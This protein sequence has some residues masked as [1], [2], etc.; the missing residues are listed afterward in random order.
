MY[1]TLIDQLDALRGRTARF[2]R[3]AVHVHSPDSRDWG[4]GAADQARNDRSRFDGDS[5]LDEFAG[6]LREH[7]DCVAVTDHMRSDF[8]TRLSSRV[9]SNDE[10]MVLPGME[11]NLR[12]EP[13][14]G[15]D[16]I[17]VLTILPEG[18]TNE[19]FSRL[20][21][22]QT[23]I[24]DDAQRTGQEDV[25]GLTLGEW[26][27]RVHKEQGIC[28]AA[29]LE[30]DQGIRCRFRQVARENLLLVCGDD[31]VEAE[32]ANSVPENL[33]H[34]LY[35]SGVDAIEIHAS[36]DVTHY[37]WVSEVDGRTR[38]I[39]TMLTFDAHNVEG[40]A[41]ADRVTHIKMT[42]LGLSGLKQALM[43]PDTRIRYP[44]NLPTPPSPRIL[45]VQIRGNED[46]F[47]ED[48][49]IAF[50]ENLNC[51]IGVRGSGKSTVVEALRYVFGYNE[52]LDELDASLTENVR[53][54]QRATLP[55]SVIRVPYRTS[56]GE[57]RV[58]EATFDE[59]ADY[60][61]KV[62]TVEGDP[63]DIDNV[64]ATGDYPLRLYGWSEIESLG[65]DPA[66][67]RDLLDRLVPDLL[68]VLQRRAEIRNEL[69]ANRGEVTR[70]IEAT[71]AA[72]QQNDG[73]IARFREF[74]GD[75]EKLN[76]AEV[77]KL[78]SALDL[79]NAKRRVLTQL[80]SNADGLVEKLQECSPVTLRDEI[81][82]L[83]DGGSEAL[84]DWWHEEE[85]ERLKV[86]AAEGEVHGFLEQ[87]VERLR[88][89]ADLVTGH[90][91]RVSAEIE[92]LQRELRER[93]AKDASMQSIADL[94]ANA[95]RRLN[96]VTGLRNAYLRAWEE[97]Q[98]AVSERRSITERLVQV[99]NEIAGI[100][101]KHNKAV[102]KKLN[103][104]LPADM[105]VSIAFRA[106]GDIKEF[107]ERLYEIFGA[108]G[109]QVKNIRRLVAE[110][111][112]PVS[113]ARMLLDSD[114]HE[115]VEG[116]PDFKEEDGTVCISRTRP[117]EHHETADVEV[118][119]ENGSCLETILDLQ[120]T[121]WDDEEVILL[122]GGPVD[123]KSPGQRSSA[124]LPLIALAQTTPLIIDQPEDNVDKR[125]IGTVLMNVLAV[126]KEKRQIIVC[127]HDA[128]ILVGGDAEQ[129]VVLEA[130]SDR[131][132]KVGQHGSIDN[133][134]I[135]DT[136]VNLLEGGAEAF[137]AR[138][139][140][141][142]G[143]AGISE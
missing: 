74:T 98:T 14:L 79:E 116:V 60:A 51:L 120:E 77:R 141:Y 44:D 57:E 115:L 124:M 99:Q 5:G 140:R 37:R 67:Q 21:H 132:G 107:A 122:N 45:G 13:P 66:R 65:R 58:L 54:L 46:S 73:E 15:F 134:D 89:F 43:F 87:A 138:R 108:R 136:V 29:H 105:E 85:L 2:R 30:N 121:A 95:E 131:K 59:K 27:E 84:R 24:P 16:R 90:V 69:R 125:L 56:S 91:N 114:V 12:L 139:K 82:E 7:L 143:H 38:S 123:R 25:M 53:K 127:T 72:F 19:A 83:L 34:Y 10:S 8:A 11:V 22:G 36:G 128:N 117:F 49:T 52:T 106:G 113:F 1:T 103:E 9:G 39:A 102:E 135:V 129:V 50:A 126:L 61:T 33:K 104:F 75:F 35:K 93:F 142:K 17:H 31:S 28:I 20:F 118:L 40:F 86:V 92:R 32:R 48:E 3:V 26:V 81:E 68:P 71:K 100:R 6:E 137:E 101:T 97:L 23:H 18:S 41:R 47:F 130:E 96:R 42:R 119:A 64:E 88:A 94:R 133:D 4:R 111:T 78:F 80:G 76:T 109:H 63:L 55:G 70:C 110:H 112:T 62:Y